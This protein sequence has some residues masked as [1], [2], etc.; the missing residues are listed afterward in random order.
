MLIKR[1]FT[2]IVMI[3]GVNLLI[4]ESHKYIFIL[5]LFVICTVGS[6]EWSKISNLDNIFHQLLLLT[7]N[8]II[9]SILIFLIINIRIL[10]KKILI[11]FLTSIPV[12]WWLIATYL[13]LT[14]S[15]SVKIWY[16]SKII[17][18]LFGIFTIVPLLY[19]IM[20]IYLYYYN[21]GLFKNALLLYL[22][23]II[24]SIDSISF[25]CGSYF[26][27]KKIIPIISPNKTWEGFIIGLILS[28]IISFTLINMMFNYNKLFLMISSIISLLLS[29]I[30]DL[31]ESMLKR[32]A[33]LKDSGNI[34]P[35][36]GGILDRIDSFSISIPI[37]TFL[38]IIF[39]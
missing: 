36:H 14:Y 30:G 38:L 17:K 11:L 27:N 32:L 33:N 3:I 8:D 39:I 10:C 22:L 19:D 37:F 4:F 16:N 9:L 20:I 1:I 12:I 5:T 31:I 7:I 6:W 35:G 29:I 34:L 21:I 28:V 2:S 24:S 26:G 18:S 13:L 25:L 23:L 15:K